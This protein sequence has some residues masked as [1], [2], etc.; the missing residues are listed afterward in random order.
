M[1]GGWIYPKRV[2]RSKVLSSGRYGVVVVVV[3]VVCLATGTWCVSESRGGDIPASD[4][5]PSVPRTRR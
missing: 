2:G 5:D 4:S 3:V 1:K